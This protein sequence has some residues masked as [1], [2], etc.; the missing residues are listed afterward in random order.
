MPYIEGKMRHRF[1]SQIE[2][3]VEILSSATVPEKD[4]KDFSSEDFSKCAG[5]L[6]YIITRISTLLLGSPSYAK[7][8][9]LTG[10]LENVK[11]EFY[12]RYASSYEDLKIIEN[13]DVKEYSNN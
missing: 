9:I 2:S 4:L 12:R 11:Q 7:I 13:G 8:A 3:I 5:N 6:N 1:D 10:V